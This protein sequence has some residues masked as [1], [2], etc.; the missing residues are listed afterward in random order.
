MDAVT[1]AALAERL[2]GINPTP[3]DTTHLLS[4]VNSLSRSAIKST[5]ITTRKANLVGP[6]S[7]PLVTFLTSKSLPFLAP[8]SSTMLQPTQRNQP[9]PKPP[10]T[11]LAILLVGKKAPRNSV[12]AAND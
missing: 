4:G 9:L 3:L 12:Q 2:A 10:T 8:C 6:T 7:A 5:K 1:T 11:M